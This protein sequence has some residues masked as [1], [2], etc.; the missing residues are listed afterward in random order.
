MRS[1]PMSQQIDDRPDYSDVLNYLKEQSEVVTGRGIGLLCVVAA[2]AKVSEG[3][4]RNIV[5]GEAEI[6]VATATAVRGACL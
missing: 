4:L 6:D 3:L 2:H 1:Q 5:A